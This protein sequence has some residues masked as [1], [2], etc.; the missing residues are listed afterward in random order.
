MV[1]RRDMLR[2]G[3]VGG[4]LGAFVSGGTPA[5]AAGQQL[6]ERYV[7][8]TAAAIDRLRSDLQAQHAFGEIAG[9]RDAQKTF[10]KVNGK[11][12]DFIDVGI[13]PWFAAYDWHV[14]WQQ[15]LVISK[16]ASGHSLL[17]LMETLL[18]LK[19]ESAPNYMGFPY[20]GR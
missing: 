19:P 4:V 1:P 11:L 16:D 9:I 5:A 13:D 6:S 2:A 7:Q 14:R 8:E 3:A 18:V 12:P 20:D 10:L 17:Q 15:P